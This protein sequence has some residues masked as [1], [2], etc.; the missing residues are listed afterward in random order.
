MLEKV[1]EVTVTLQVSQLE[2]ISE[3]D[4]RELKANVEELW[5]WMVYMVTKENA[6]RERWVTLRE[7]ECSASP[8]I[9]FS[10]SRV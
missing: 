5:S 7:S 10:F 9:Y 4:E 8:N 2:V 3:S 1:R 6:E